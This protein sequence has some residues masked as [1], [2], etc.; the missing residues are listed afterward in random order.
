MA[1]RTAIGTPTPAWAR[2]RVGYLL[3]AIEAR[4]SYEDESWLVVVVTDHG[5]TDSGGHGGFTDGERQ[6]VMITANLN[7]DAGPTTDGRLVDVAPT[8]L[9]HVGLPSEVVRG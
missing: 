2:T 9:G 5:H 6:T 3:E 8:V 4:P 7:G 1:R